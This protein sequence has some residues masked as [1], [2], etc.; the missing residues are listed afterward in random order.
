MV[1][2]E[3]DNTNRYYISGFG[4]LADF[5]DSDEDHSTAV[6]SR[7]GR[8]AA[9]DLLFYQSELAELQ[10]RQDQYD[11][12]DANEALSSS[13]TRRTIRQHT[14]DWVTF[15]NIASAN[16]PTSDTYT[17]DRWK[18][19]M[20]LAMNIRKTLVEYQEALI[21]HSKVLSFS[22][23]TE[24]TMKALSGYFHTRVAL[25]EAEPQMTTLPMLT[26]ASSNLYPRDMDERQI[27]SSDYVTL[28]LQPHPDLL[29]NFLGTYVSRCFR[30]REP[31]LLPQHR[32]AISHI[33]RDE[34]VRYPL[35]RIHFVATLISTFFAGILLFL[36]I[37]VLYHI[38]SSQPNITIGLI[39]M[40]VAIF[41]VAIVMMT[42]ARR[43]EVFGACAAYAAVLVVFVSGD[44]A[45]AVDNT[46]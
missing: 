9:R 13:E 35:R 37:F 26:G 24:Q 18:K 6:Y 42:N 27:R 41:A 2:E 8:L 38:A 5:I 19:R 36:P 23:P 1:H 20:D 31:P 32:A 45:A 28:K 29:T 3:Q 25:N 40:F 21:R 11:L 44:F 15:Q 39:A 46:G 22:Q 12:E 43:A 34:V 14:R 30:T 10:S 7:F 4:A 16:T 17:S 33:P